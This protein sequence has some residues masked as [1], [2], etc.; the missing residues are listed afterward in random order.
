MS[1]TKA[2]PKLVEVYIPTN[3]ATCVGR[4]GVFPVL[5]VCVE[6]TD[7]GDARIG[8]VSRK[9]RRRVNAGACIPVEAMDK[10]ATEWIRMRGLGSLELPEKSEINQYVKQLNNIAKSMLGMVGTT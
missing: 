4:N 9:L 7:D 10:L 8:F 5:M 1:G 2:S 6:C 3:G